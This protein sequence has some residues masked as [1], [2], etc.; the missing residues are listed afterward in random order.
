MFEEAALLA[1]LLL[2][3]V[4]R[5][6]YLGGLFFLD[7]E[8]ALKCAGSNLQCCPPASPP[9]PVPLEEL[10]GKCGVVL[11]FPNCLTGRVFKLKLH[12]Y[13]IALCFLGENPTDPHFDVIL[14]LFSSFHVTF[15]IHFLENMVWVNQVLEL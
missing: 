8:V 4:I 1:R 14:Q 5:F 9:T 11:V 7:E 2:P 15:Q 6:P 3:A 12:L 13:H 10:R